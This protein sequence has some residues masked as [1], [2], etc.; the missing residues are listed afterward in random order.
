MSRTQRRFGTNRHHRKPLS[1]NG[2]NHHSNVSIVPVVKHFLWH[3]MFG[4]MTPEEI[5][6][7]INKVWLDPAYEFICRRKE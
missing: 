2:R 1:Q 4:T 7:R 3:E 5:C 6:T